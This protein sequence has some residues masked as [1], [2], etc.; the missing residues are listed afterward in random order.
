MIESSGDFDLACARK[1]YSHDRTFINK[2]REKLI[3]ISADVEAA[4]EFDEEGEVY[5]TR[6]SSFEKTEE[7][8]ATLEK[9]IRTREKIKSVE[10]FFTVVIAGPTNAG[11]S[12]LFNLLLGKGRSIVHSEAGT[13]RDL[14]SET[15]WLCGYQISLI[16]SAGIRA[17]N[18][19]IEKEGIIRSREAMENASLVLWVTD[20]NR[21]LSNEE[22]D[23]IQTQDK[24]K[25]I[26]V[27]NK[28]DLSPGN[29]KKC[30]LEK[31]KIESISVSIKE[32]TKTEAIINK[33]GEKLES[34]HKN[35]E[36]PDIFLNK[37]QEEIGKE[38]Y[39]ELCCARDEWK[40]QEIAAHHLKNGIKLLD[41]IFGK[42]EN[43]EI[44]NKIFSSFCIGK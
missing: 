6:N 30:A 38:L 13:T 33:I 27:I 35:I 19:E 36:I 26:C 32:K 23:E 5:K 4:I 43:E 37:R 22:L 41:E 24:E 34:I 39:K 20:A 1:L 29:E 40:R 8:I 17:T 11:K 14:I 28:T 12:S 10:N 42:T 25:V 18:H 44:L 7:I 2:I 21:A 16:D 3:E 9:E 31:L 15:V